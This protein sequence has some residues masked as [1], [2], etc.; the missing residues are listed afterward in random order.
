MPEMLFQVRPVWD[1]EAQ[2]FY[3]DSNIIGLHIE[4][5]TID[6]F[7]AEVNAVARE[8]IIANHLSKRD[9]VQRSL[10]D[11]IPSILMLP[12]QKGPGRAALA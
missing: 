9:L 3:S 4:A 12:F 7:I 10:I 6:E 1:D 11:L 5:E 2:I 8:L